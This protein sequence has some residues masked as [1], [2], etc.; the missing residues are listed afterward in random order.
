MNE[1][2]KDDIRIDAAV[3]RAQLE[4]VG[5]AAG[6]EGN[7]DEGSAVLVRPG[8]VLRR[9]KLAEALEGIR[10]RIAEDGHFGGAA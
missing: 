10:E 8:D 9:F 7:G 6:R 1:Q 5:L 2:G 3:E 4:A